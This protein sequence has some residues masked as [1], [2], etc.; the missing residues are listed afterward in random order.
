LPVPKVIRKLATNYQKIRGGSKV[1]PELNNINGKVITKYKKYIDRNPQFVFTNLG[2]HT[3]G[4]QLG[5]K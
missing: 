1:L 4:N 5:R 2:H 3:Y